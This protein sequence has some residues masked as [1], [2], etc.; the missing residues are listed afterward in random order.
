M[1]DVKH[2][3]RIG[4]SLVSIA[5]KMALCARAPLRELINKLITR[6]GFT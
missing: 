6:Y 3:A 2:S 1:T 4:M 5:I